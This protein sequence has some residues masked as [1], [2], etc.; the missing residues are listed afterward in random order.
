MTKAAAESATPTSDQG[1]YFKF[2][3]II[4]VCL[5]NSLRSRYFFRLLL[6][7]A[8]FLKKKKNNFWKNSFSNT[9]RV[10][11]G[12]DQDQ[13][14]RFVGPDLGKNCLQWVISRRQKSPL[15]RYVSCV[16]HAF[17]SVHCWLAVICW[18]RADLLAL[19]GDVY[20][21][22]CLLLAHPVS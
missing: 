19:V 16:S 11:N 12:I 18:E 17:A 13:D 4:C 10:S 8:D 15:A 9:I 21:I 1:I 22:V 3:N 5:I 2:L 20:S 6:S 7:S 14:R